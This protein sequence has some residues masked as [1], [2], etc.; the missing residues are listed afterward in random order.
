M[1]TI[2]RPNPETQARIQEVKLGMDWDVEHF[3]VA[4]LHTGTGTPGTAP[5]GKPERFEAL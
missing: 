5:A 4:R 3:R 2:T 1:K